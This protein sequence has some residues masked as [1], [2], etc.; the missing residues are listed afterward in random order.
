LWAAIIIRDSSSHPLSGWAYELRKRLGFH[1][2]QPVRNALVWQG[3]KAIRTAKG[4][5]PP[6]APAKADNAKPLKGDLKPD[7]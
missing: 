6:G 3:P 5:S 7:S 4:D 1:P 2:G